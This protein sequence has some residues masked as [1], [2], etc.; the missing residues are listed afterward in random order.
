[1]A[2]RK[3]IEVAIPLDAINAACKAEKDRKLGTLRNLHKWFAPMPLPAWRALLFASLVDDPDDETERDN[4]L[5]LTEALVEGGIRLPSH[6]TL[7]SAREAI[8]KSWP[9]GIP[10]V[11]DPFCG[12]GSTLVEAQR[13]GCSTLGT[14][15]NPVPVLLTRAV[16]EVLPACADRQALHDEHL[17]GSLG[18]FEGLITDCRHYARVVVEGAWQTLKPYYPRGAGWTPLAYLWC[19]TVRCPNPACGVSAPLLS[20]MWISKRRDDQHHLRIAWPEGTDDAEFYVDPGAPTATA[21]VARSGGRCAKC[22]AVIPFA[23]IREEARSGR[24]GSRLTTV[25][26]QAND[27]KRRYRAAT[28]HDE[29]TARSAADAEADE[30]RLT[31]LTGKATQN[32]GL[33]GMTDHRD[34]FIGR[35]RLALSVF[36]RE[37]RATKDRV[38]ADGGDAQYA[39]AVVLMLGLGVGKMAQASSTIVRWNT[40]VAPNRSPK[41]EPAFARHDMPMP[42]DF[43]ET[44]PFGGSVG[45]FI[46][47]V[48]TAIRS[49]EHVVPGGRGRAEQADVRQRAAKAVDEAPRMIATDPPY[50]DAINYADLSDHFYMWLRKALQDVEPDLFRTIT[51]PK[52]EELIASPWRHNGDRQAARRYFIDG[53]TDAF[54]ELRRVQHPDA[55]MLVI[56]AHRE[57]G[58]NNLTSGAGW[59]AILAALVAADLMIV[60]TWPISGA[61]GARMVGVGSNALATYVTL[62]CR[63]RPT[64]AHSITKQDLARALR[65]ALKDAV[66]HL[67][68]ANVAPVDLAQ[69]VIGPGMQVFSQHARVVETDGSPVRVGD[70][71]RM[72]NQT[73]AE[74]LDE[75]EGDLDQE[76]RWAVTW[77]EQHGFTPATFG[78][79]D[80]LARAKGIAVD[81][82]VVAGVATSGGSKVALIPRAALLPSW[83]PAKDLRATAWEAVQYLVRALEQ[84]GETAAA[85]L[86]AR[87]G[88]LCDPARELAYRLFQIAEKDRRTEEA[89]AYNGLVMSW[90]EIARLAEAI[91]SPANTPREPEALF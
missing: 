51:T 64:D 15:L 54:L 89:L 9:D 20:T 40:A 62:V 46:Q 26:D 58:G 48:N 13:L 31:P 35:Q 21:T 33:Y 44:D 38:V 70:A 19:R 17:P 29:A 86:Y 74:V 71:L 25:V 78:E 68:H 32:V 81:S 87:L 53:F 1:M 8:A 7:H 27:S 10:E 72:I 56:Y 16:S 83:D 65:Q 67:Q 11:W 76:S 14:D 90:P 5:R 30:E 50:F 61:R 41:A 63:P 77:Y 45:D 85:D 80:Q 66:T 55:P 47:V 57:H 84:G 22:D 24:L 73:L 12:G 37:V 3:L 34:L 79:A 18:P 52:G 69:A 43:A 60:G 23:Y 82:L 49:L 2:K 42:W 6:A 88:P 91:P 75:Q 59:E 28:A 39:E 4:L 36:A